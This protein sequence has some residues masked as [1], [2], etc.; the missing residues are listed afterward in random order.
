MALLVVFEVGSHPLA[1]EHRV[2]ALEDPLP[3]AMAELADPLVGL[4]LVQCRVVGQIEQ[5]HVVEIPAVGDV[6]PAE[7]LDP[8]LLL[9]L[10]DLPVEEGPHV[11]LEERVATTADGEPGREHGHGHGPPLMGKS[12][13]TIGPPAWR[14]N[15]RPIVAWGLRRAESRRP[16]RWAGSSAPSPAR[17]RARR[18]SSCRSPAGGAGSDG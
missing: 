9:V 6:V 15:G 8:V 16:P 1:E 13:S 14:P 2:M 5:D 7:E 3:R 17:P 10:A 18:P 4:Q 11:E 12:R